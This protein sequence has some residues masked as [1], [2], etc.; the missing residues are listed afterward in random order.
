MAAVLGIAAGYLVL[1]EDV[2]RVPERCSPAY[3]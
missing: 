1:L 3:P 2:F